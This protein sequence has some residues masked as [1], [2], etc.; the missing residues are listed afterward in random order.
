MARTA[1]ALLQSALH[2]RRQKHST[3]TERATDAATQ[4]STAQMASTSSTGNATEHASPNKRKRAVPLI[5]Q[6]IHLAAK[7]ER[8]KKRVRH[9]LCFL[10]QQTGRYE[11]EYGRYEPWW[12]VPWPPMPHIPNLHPYIAELIKELRVL[13]E[14]VAKE[15][16]KLEF[17]KEVFGSFDD[18]TEFDDEDSTDNESGD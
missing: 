14:E 2:T 9:R 10:M 7:L 1:T 5:D 6:E 16:R 18:E 13:R 8:Q 12:H 3:A 4:D 15:G 11:Q 17:C